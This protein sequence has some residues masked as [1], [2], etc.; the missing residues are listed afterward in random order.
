MSRRNCCSVEVKERHMC[1]LKFDDRAKWAER[2]PLHPRCV[3]KTAI[4][5]AERN[6]DIAPPTRGALHKDASFEICS[7]GKPSYACQGAQMTGINAS[8]RFG[9]PLGP[10][11]A[12][13]Q[14]DLSPRA[15]VE[16]ANNNSSK[17]CSMALVSKD[18]ANEMWC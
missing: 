2:S 3:P 13:S 14:G 15:I 12:S 10:T 5:T 6:I 4:K 16:A 1:N 18:S 17:D 7:L 11:L 9:S 8:Y